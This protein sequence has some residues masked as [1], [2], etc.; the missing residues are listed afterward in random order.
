MIKKNHGHVVAISS[1]AGFFGAP[2]GTLYCPSKF[3]VRGK[4]THT[5]LVCIYRV[6]KKDPG[7]ILSIDVKKTHSC[8]SK[9]FCSYILQIA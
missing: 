7:F 9:K 4:N 8:F 3:A 1:I 6:S 5:H 2:Y